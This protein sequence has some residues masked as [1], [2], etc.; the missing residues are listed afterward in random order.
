MYTNIK[1]GQARLKN[2]WAVC[3]TA[4]WRLA[5]RRAACFFVVTPF[6]LAGAMAPVSAVPARSCFP[7][8]RRWRRSRFCKWDRAG[9]VR[10]PSALQPSNVD[11]KSGARRIRYAEYI[12]ATQIP[13]RWQTVLWVAAGAPFGRPAPASAGRARRMWETIDFVWAAGA[14]GHQHGLYQRRRLAEGGWSP[15]RRNSVMDCEV[16]EQFSA[17]SG[18][19]D[20]GQHPRPGPRH[21]HPIAEVGAGGHFFGAASTRR[22]AIRKCVLPARS[23]PTAAIYEAWQ[24]AGGPVDGGTAHGIVQ[25]QSWA[26]FRA[27]ADGGRDPRGD[28]RAFVARRKDRGRRADGFLEP[29]NA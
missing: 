25:A 2:D 26:E 21:R 20:A 6:T 22:T 8:P 1:L 11:M 7:S 3:S 5:R 16:A 24:T 23:C 14:I 29:A 15:A 12:R 17:L 18:A 19:A 4:R 9:L 27:A 10:S 28:G 13:A